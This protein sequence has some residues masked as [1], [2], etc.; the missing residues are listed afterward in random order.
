MIRISMI[1]T[2]KKDHFGAIPFV[3]L[4]LGFNCNIHVFRES[5]GKYTD[6]IKI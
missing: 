2:T 5:V 6:A 3:V 1:E 4:K